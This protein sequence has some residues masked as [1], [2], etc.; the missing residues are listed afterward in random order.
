MTYRNTLP[1]EYLFSLWQL[2][3]NTFSYFLL[4]RNSEMRIT[5]AFSLSD[6]REL[7][8]KCLKDSLHTPPPNLWFRNSTFE[9]NPGNSLVSLFSPGHPLHPSS[10]QSRPGLAPV[11]HRWPD[12]GLPSPHPSV[13]LLVLRLGAPLLL[14]IARTLF[15]CL[16][17]CTTFF[18]FS[19]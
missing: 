12:P 15:C 8:G 14:L 3:Q 11:G 1:P 9:N 5:Q 4:A 19:C 16:I 10:N 7:T 17:N 18:F 13:V 6:E 2:P